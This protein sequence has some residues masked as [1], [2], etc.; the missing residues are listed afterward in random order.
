MNYLNVKVMS[1]PI[2]DVFPFRSS[3]HPCSVLISSSSRLLAPS[4]SQTVLRVSH[5]TF[6]PSFK[7]C[8]EIIMFLMRED[9]TERVK[10]GGGGIQPIGDKEQLERWSNSWYTCSDVDVMSLWHFLILFTLLQL[11][12]Y[13]FTL[14]VN[15][16][17]SK[18]R[19]GRRVI[20]Q[21]LSI[22]ITRLYTIPA[23]IILASLHLP[24]LLLYLCYYSLYV[25]SNRGMGGG[26]GVEPSGSSLHQGR[27]A[28][29]VLPLTTRTGWAGEL[30]KVVKSTI[31]FSSQ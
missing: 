27:Q 8:N 31:R 14:A 5:W 3:C 19:F 26:E 28:K 15:K 30:T 1:C 13:L 2:P 16:W 18:Y 12:S 29:L 23:T 20:I 22:L 4:L 17:R 10:E 25:V 6:T 24:H 7:W 21:V 11:L 9:L